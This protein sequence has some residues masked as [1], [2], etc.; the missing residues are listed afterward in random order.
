MWRNANI[1]LHA[2]FEVLQFFHRSLSSDGD[3]HRFK[4][5]SISIAIENHL[6][7]DRMRLGNSIDSH[8]LKLFVFTLL[9]HVLVVKSAHIRVAAFPK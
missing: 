2:F 3:H 7:V 9:H 1:K 6:P 5:E 8:G 4:N